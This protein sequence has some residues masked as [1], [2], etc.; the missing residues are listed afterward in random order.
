MNTQGLDKKVL[1]RDDVWMSL[2][3]AAILNQVSLADEAATIIL[4][5]DDSKIQIVAASLWVP[6]DDFEEAAST[7]FCADEYV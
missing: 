2:M 5:N 6:L 7:R 1:Q 4:P 3:L